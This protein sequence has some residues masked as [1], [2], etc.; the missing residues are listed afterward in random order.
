MFEAQKQ[1]IGRESALCCNLIGIGVTNLGRADYTNM[2]H[3]YTAFFCLT[4]GL[5]RMAKL[6]LVA[7]YAIEK[8]AM[9]SPSYLKN[10]GHELDVL[11]EKCRDLIEKYRFALTY[12]YPNNQICEKII[13]CLDNFAAASKGRYANFTELYNTTLYEWEPVRQWWNEVAKLIVKKHFYDTRKE[14]VDKDF[15][16]KSE[17]SMTPATV[18][19]STEDG[20][21]LYD[22]GSAVYR[23]KQAETIQ[24]YGRFYTLNIVRW[25]AEFL[26]NIA[27][28]AANEHQIKAFWGLEEYYQG[29]YILPD[30]FLKRR[31]TWPI[32]KN[33]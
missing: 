21:K 7:D 13:K 11:F 32:L 22:I 4:V 18:C 14:K 30:A 26:C 23:K 28:I 33:Y 29:N 19:L 15:A 3:Y 27:K 31:K 16:R 12:P 20:T 10:Y 25:L 2:G 6:A 8:R 24:R 5:E 1:A 17:Q 9:P